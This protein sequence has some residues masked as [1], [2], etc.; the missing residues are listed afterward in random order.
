MSSKRP[1]LSELMCVLMA[2]YCL[3]CPKVSSWRT[4]SVSTWVSWTWRLY[5]ITLKFG[6]AF[7]SDVWKSDG[8]SKESNRV[9]VGA[10]R[11]TPVNNVWLVSISDSGNLRHLAGFNTGRRW[12]FIGWQ[13]R[14]ESPRI[15]PEIWRGDNITR[16]TSLMLCKVSAK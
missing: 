14:L 8:V 13:S 7:E 6:G 4:K 11:V 10:C 12:Q 5:C 1:I 9:T 2:P 3:Y 15:R 16:G